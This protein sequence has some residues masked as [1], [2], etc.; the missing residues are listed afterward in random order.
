MMTRNVGS[1]QSSVPSGYTDYPWLKVSVFTI[2]GTVE[3]FESI[4]YPG[5]LA[6]VTIFAEITRGLLLIAPAV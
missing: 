1:H 3:F 5:W 4:G 6:Y 2:T